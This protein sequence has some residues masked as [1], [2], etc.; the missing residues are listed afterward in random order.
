MGDIRAFFL[1]EVK[2]KGWEIFNYLFIRKT[3]DIAMDFGCNE[4]EGC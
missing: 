2:S 1:E 4:K 3:I